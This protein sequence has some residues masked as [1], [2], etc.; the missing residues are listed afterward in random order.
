MDRNK[1]L[2]IMNYFLC[3]IEDLEFICS[4]PM[5]TTSLSV[6]DNM[7]FSTRDLIKELMKT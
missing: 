5:V 2:I 4:Y 1:F 7:T 6:I 3:K